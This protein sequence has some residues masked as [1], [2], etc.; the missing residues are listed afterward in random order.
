[1][2]EGAHRFIKEADT[3][4]P[5]HYARRVRRLAGAYALLFAGSLA[6]IGLILWQGEL[7]V[8]LAQRT[9]VETLTLAFFLVFFG[10]IAVLTAPGAVGALRVAYYA[11][12]ARLV[13]RAEVERRKDR[14]LGP[15]TAVTPAVALNAVLERDGRPGEP[16]AVPA[17]DAF[18][19]MGV[20]EVDGAEV[21]HA[22]ARRNG[23]NSLLA[24]FV[25]QVI[26]VLAERGAAAQLD[27]VNWKQIDDEATEQYLGLVRFARNLEK[28]L[29]GAEL[30]PKVTLTDSDCRELERRLAAVCPAV[31]DEEFLPD[32]EYAAEHKLPLIPEP[33][34]LVSLSR[35]ERRVDPVASMG[36][37][38][39]VVAAAVVVLG[40]LITF[41]PWVP[42]K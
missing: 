36:C 9:N 33:L 11:A 3:E 24:Y 23:S 16:F 14:A 15:P 35:T 1:V 20:L 40:L 27:I 31:R 37:A 38:V 5:Q 26:R 18:G 41:P 30:W 6:G 12:L 32:W 21:R 29:G 4:D 42:G 25:E 39:L 22:R 13:G 2:A 28:Q 34:G 10:Y 7:L 19:S 8:T 17:A